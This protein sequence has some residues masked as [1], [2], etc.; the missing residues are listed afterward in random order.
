[1]AEA[2]TETKRRAPAKPKRPA[3]LAHG[4]WLGD[5]EPLSDAERNFVAC[6]A[7]GEPCGLESSRPEVSTPT[8][9][10]RAGLIRFL[11]LG[12]DDAHPVHEKGV[13]LKGAWITDSLDLSNVQ[14]VADLNLRNCYL[15]ET[16]NAQDSRLLGLNLGGSQVPGLQASGM[17]VTGSVLLRNG[18]S[19]TS[20]VWLL[21]AEIGGDLDCNGGSF[22]GVNAE[23][24]P[25][26]YALFAA[27]VRVAGRV[28]LRDGFTAI[29][30]VRLL[31]AQIGVFLSC[32]GGS[33]SNIGQNGTSHGDA[34]C[35]DSMV[36][37]GG[38]YMNR[39][40]FVGTVDFTAAH[41]GSLIDDDQ[42][43]P[44]KGAVLDGFHYDRIAAGPTNADTRIAWLNKQIPKHLAEE[45]RPQPWEQL[46]KVLR[47]MGHPAVAAEVAI[48]KQQA[49]RKAAVIKGP[50]R[51][52]L[53]WLYGL[54][55]GYGHRP[56]RTVGAMFMVCLVCSLFFYAGRHAGLFGPSN[57]LISANP[58]FEKCADG[59][60]PGKIHW[61]SPEC[62][63]PAEYTT[64]QPFFYSLDLILPL[65][66]LQQEHDWSPIVQSAHGQTLWEGCALRWLMW[67]EIL[68]G[69]VASLIL[70]AVLGRLVEKD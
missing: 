8:N 43:W 1:M 53:H 69:W 16:L 68:F 55:A 45:F 50:L 23:G 27:G 14:T 35:A 29:G 48:A 15:A 17:T 60:V 24:N 67:F 57:P 22:R 13:E 52:A 64:F 54:L 56:S 28:F 51:R 36:V 44:E 3:H 21:G 4:R 2:P 6:C 40:R 18:F 34:L 25:T 47:E 58:R 7:R 26:G 39:G 10:I 9:T 31:G 62:P 61:T 19:A 66:D 63:I 37:K 59:G 32:S 46:I 42:C 49:M 65:V 38:L 33:F 20:E 70:V 11:V 41:V 30:E 5:F 12:G